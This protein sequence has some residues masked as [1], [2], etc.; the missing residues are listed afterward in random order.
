M[1]HVERGE[2]EEAGVGAVD[3]DG[4]GGEAESAT[5]RRKTRPRLTVQADVMER[6][7]VIAE[8]RE[9]SASE[10]AEELLSRYLDGISEEDLEEIER[11]GALGEHVEGDSAN[12]DADGGTHD[13]EK[14]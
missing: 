4:E 7:R 9:M 13:D 11:S 14:G 1:A 10:L 3:Y 6:L 2:H 8:Q 12:G 5:R